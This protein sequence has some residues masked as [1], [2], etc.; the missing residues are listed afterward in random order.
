MIISDFWLTLVS[1]V[2]I[3]LLLSMSL[4]WIGGKLLTGNQRK[5]GGSANREKIR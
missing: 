4:R 2:V 3:G 1:G 5:E